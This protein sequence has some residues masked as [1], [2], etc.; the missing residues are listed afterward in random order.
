MVSSQPNTTTIAAPVVNIDPAPEPKLVFRGLHLHPLTRLPTR[1]SLYLHVRPEAI[2]RPLLRTDGNGFGKRKVSTHCAFRSHAYSDEK[3]RGHEMDMAC[4]DLDEEEMTEPD[5]VFD[6]GSTMT[7]MTRDVA[8][9]SKFNSH[10]VTIA[11]RLSCSMEE[12]KR[13]VI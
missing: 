9:S 6:T 12:R 4:V 11:T 5:N 13:S 8:T 3:S 10:K 7:T 2:R 1:P